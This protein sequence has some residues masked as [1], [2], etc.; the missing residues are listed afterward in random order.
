MDNAA[1]IARLRASGPLPDARLPDD[2]SFPLQEFDDLLQ[3]FT[4]PLTQAQAIQ[5]INLGPPADC[6]CYGVEW[7]LVHLV[8]LLSVEDSQQAVPLAND[9]E[10]KRILEIRLANYLKAQAAL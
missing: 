8:E 4:E 2:D 9:T 7:S 3:Q 1:L 5:L 6:G 10:V